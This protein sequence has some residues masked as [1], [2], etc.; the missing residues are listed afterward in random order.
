MQES[1]D[2]LN[3]QAIEL[4]SRGNFTEAIACYKRAITIERENSLLWF[5]LG[6]TYQKQ[7]DLRAAKRAFSNALEMNPADEE[8]AEQL[9]IVCLER[10]EF[11]EAA[12]HCRFG[13]EQNPVNAHLWNTLGVIFFNQ[14][15]YP[16][17]AESFERAVSI[18]PYYY[19][20]LYNLR[21]TYSELGNKAGE[22]VCEER[23]SKLKEPKEDL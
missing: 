16:T 4:A 22:A 10:K 1:A 5:N 17:A 19:D 8:S 9:A 7:G 20:A 3:N 6:V 14:E 15:E 11:M 18:N 2:F 12:E 13:L 23:L 21:D